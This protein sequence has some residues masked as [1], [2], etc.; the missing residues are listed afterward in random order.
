MRLQ[1]RHDTDREVGLAGLRANG[2]RDRAGGDTRDLAEE[3]AAKGP[4][5]RSR[6]GIVR[7][8][9]RCGTGARS[10]VSS[11]CVQI[12]RRLAWQLGQK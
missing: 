10:A 6:L 9:C 2:G 7:T 4:Y 12:A 5:A 1:T 3:T 8:T 11:H